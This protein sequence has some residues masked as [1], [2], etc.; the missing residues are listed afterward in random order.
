MTGGRAGGDPAREAALHTA[1]AALR[2]AQRLQQVLD[3]LAAARRVLSPVG[4]VGSGGEREVAH[5]AEGLSAPSQ[6]KLDDA[7]CAV[8]ITD[9]NTEDDVDSRFPSRRYGAFIDELFRTTVPRWGGALSAGRRKRLVDDLV[10]K[11]GGWVS[12]VSEWVRG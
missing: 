8:S 11:V 9:A 12:G 7:G 2:D 4:S 1:T 10:L 5:A 3:A 6:A